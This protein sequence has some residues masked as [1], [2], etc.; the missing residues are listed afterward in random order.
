[1]VP[2]FLASWGPVASGGLVR[3]GAAP[4]GVEAPALEA[5]GAWTGSRWTGWQEIWRV[6]FPGWFY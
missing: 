3:P 5:Q 2:P 6:G 4:E 1:M